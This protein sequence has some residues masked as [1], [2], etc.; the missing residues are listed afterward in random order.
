MYVTYINID[1][2]TKKR[3]YLASNVAGLLLDY[4]DIK[5]GDSL[6]AAQDY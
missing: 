5:N 6:L 4:E 3:V 2:S 1:I